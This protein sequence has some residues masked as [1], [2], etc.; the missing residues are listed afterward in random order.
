MNYTDKIQKLIQTK[1]KY[2]YSLEGRKANFQTRAILIALSH[3]VK[4]S[5]LAKDLGIST[6][7]IYEIKQSYK[8]KE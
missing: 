6:S 2:K 1:E 4:P 3:D 5:V 7:R 8:I